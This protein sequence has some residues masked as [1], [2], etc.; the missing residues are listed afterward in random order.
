MFLSSHLLA[1]MEQ[2]AEDLVVIHKGRIRYQ[3]PM[4]QLGT[5]GQ[6][7]LMV[8]VGQPRARLVLDQLGFPPCEGRR[9]W[10]Q[11]PESESPRVAA[12]LVEAGCDLFELVP[13][14]ANLEARF[15]ALLEEA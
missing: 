14:K 13:H 3:G 10:I 6:A 12:C 15:L 2:V 11:A 4:A 1:E 7:E 8:R 9:I 5:A